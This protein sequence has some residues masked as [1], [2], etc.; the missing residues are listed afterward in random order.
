MPDNNVEKVREIMTEAETIAP[1]PDAVAP[2]EPRTPPEGPPADSPEADDDGPVKACADLPLNDYGNGQ[3]FFI[4]FGA[5]LLFVP[6]V[7]WFCWDGVMWAKD[8][9]GVE[10][11]RKAQ[12]V[13]GLIKRE[14]PHLVLDERQMDK[15][16][17][18]RA[19]VD[20]LRALDKIEKMTDEQ[21]ERHQLLLSKSAA[22][23]SLEALLGQKK[24]DHHRHAKNAGN[25]APMKHMVEQGE[26]NLH[27][28]YEA[29]DADPLLVNTLS[30]VLKF[31]VDEDAR[32]QLRAEG[33]SDF[34][35]I[36]K[37]SMVPHDRALRLTKAMQL[38]Y[39]P[40]A[41]CP[42]FDAFLARI[43]PEEDMR[44]FLQRWFGLSMTALI[45]DQKMV[46]LY[47]MGANGKS[48]LVDL[49]S[50][51]LD[52]YAATAKIESLTGS[53]KR[54]GAEA[55]PDLV[56]L[57]GA[58][59]VRA[60]EPEQGAPLKE[61]VI[62][63]L[64]G[65]E[66]ILVRALNQ[67]FVEVL[68]EFKLTISGNHKPEIRGTDDGIWRR[69]L[70]T[71]FDVQIPQAERDPKL[72]EKLWAERSGILNWLIAGL[73]DYLENGLQEPERIVAA[74]QEFREESDPVHSFLVQCC[75]VTGNEQD[76]TRSKDLVEAFQFWQRERGE[77][78]WKDTTVARRL[79]DKAGKWREPRS[80]LLFS[81]HK[82][83]VS[84][85]RGIRLTDMFRKRRDDIEMEARY[86][87]S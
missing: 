13:A 39:D 81:K 80:G 6:R 34:D 42:K 35:G 64:T 40:D 37:V 31:E 28:P 27:C 3:R 66:P 32:R 86:G 19:I 26:I 69:V 9:D 53:S 67:D 25:A 21:K 47:G 60:S 59:M 1:D 18:K 79:S 8:P 77:T 7:G 49:M 82:A 57:M 24:R 73:I 23:S 58:R 29:L 41:T 87:K 52:G 15:L 11:R 30:G 65:G 4:H 17:E 16:A 46:F 50:R 5:D 71:P 22:I 45:G 14:I 33:C 56:P 20:E 83:S 38:E 44:A 63:E 76:F 43:Q 55:T 72:G 85:Y 75:E 2:D 36:A 74:T 70:L 61:S 12:G 48:V 62:K 78:P 84:G 68:P 54:S 51:M 10:V